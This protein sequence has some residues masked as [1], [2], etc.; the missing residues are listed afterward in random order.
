LHNPSQKLI[1]ITYQKKQPRLSSRI[2]IKQFHCNPITMKT[3]SSSLIVFALLSLPY[4]LLAQST[5]VV[6]TYAKHILT[7]DLDV[8]EYQITL[9]NDGT[10]TF[11]YYSKLKNRIPTEDH[12]EGHGTWVLEKNIVTFTNSTSTAEMPQNRLD[13]SE[14]QARW[15]APSPRNTSA[16]V[17][18]QQLLFLSSKVNWLPRLVLE[19]T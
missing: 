12:K 6:G 2:K 4:S 15:M 10:F 13:F 11:S 8:L 17:K 1:Y 3:F 14:T 18:P 16:T 5:A 19:K 9:K 7:V